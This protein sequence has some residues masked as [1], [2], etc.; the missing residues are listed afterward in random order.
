[1]LLPVSQHNDNRHSWFDLQECLDTLPPTLECELLDFLYIADLK[2]VK[3]FTAMPGT[4][5][6]F[7][8]HLYIKVIVLPR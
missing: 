5:T 3:C 8:S 1:M 7:L 2:N 4:K 6:G